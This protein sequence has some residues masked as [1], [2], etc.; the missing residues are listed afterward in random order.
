MRD[1]ISPSVNGGKLLLDPQSIWFG[2]WFYKQYWW[3]NNLAKQLT[4][5]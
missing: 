5:A 3:L 1:Q 2:V 4:R